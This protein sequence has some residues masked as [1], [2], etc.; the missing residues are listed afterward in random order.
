MQSEAKITRLKSE[1]EDVHHPQIAKL[2]RE[3]HIFSKLEDNKIVSLEWAEKDQDQ[4][5]VNFIYNLLLQITF[6][7]FDSENSIYQQL[8]IA[9][10]FVSLEE[11]LTSSKTTFKRLD[12]EGIAVSE[13]HRGT[14][15]YQ[16]ILNVL[17][18][19]KIGE[20]ASLFESEAQQG[21]VINNIMNALF[22]D[23]GK[24]IIARDD[25]EQYHAEISYL[26]TKEFGLLTEDQLAAIRYHHIFELLDK[27]KVSIDQ[28][29]KIFSDATSFAHLSILSSADV[30]S[31]V[32]YEAYAIGGL[33]DIMKLIVLGQF[34]ETQ[35]INILK[36]IQ[37]QVTSYLDVA[38]ESLIKNRN[39]VEKK[40]AQMKVFI[41]QFTS[42]LEDMSLVVINE[43]IVLLDRLFQSS[44][45]GNA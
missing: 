17:K 44:V 43:I 10:F 9:G 37:K 23:W 13:A 24:L 22:H 38:S 5:L 18:E 6:D 16:H 15:P 14:T 35:A 8:E 45:Y 11:Y 2:L 28:I 4:E 42:D 34:D 26:M 41:E 1:W 19:L 27:G 12:A 21:F 3:K 33:L 7:A 30:A 29:R 31:V 25:T 40:M 20:F 39:Y 32:S 36:L